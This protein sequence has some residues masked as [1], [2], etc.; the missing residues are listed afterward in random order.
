[1]SQIM[2]DKN[3]KIVK[4]SSNSFENDENSLNYDDYLEGGI[5][6]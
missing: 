4:S 2:K 3:K 5:V 1:M 6:E